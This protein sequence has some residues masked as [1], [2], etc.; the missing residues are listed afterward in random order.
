MGSVWARSAFALA[1]AAAALAHG[2]EGELSVGGTRQTAG[3]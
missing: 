1:A 3:R 2:A